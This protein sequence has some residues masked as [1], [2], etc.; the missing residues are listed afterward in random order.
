M[1]AADAGSIYA[2]TGNG[3]YDGTAN[4]GESLLRL[5]DNL[6]VA[7]SLTP[8]NRSGL[9]TGDQEMGTARPVLVPNSNLILGGNKGGTLYVLDHAQLGGIQVGNQKA[10]QTF[11]ALTG[12]IFDLALW[13]S[14]S[15][16]ILV[17]QGEQDGLKAF[18]LS[19]H[20]FA[21]EPCSSNPS[22]VASAKG[23]MAVSANGSTPGTTI[24]WITS[25]AEP[26][27]PLASGRLPAFDASDVSKELWN[28]DIKGG[29][30]TLGSFAKFANPTIAGGKVYV[31]TFSGQLVVYGLY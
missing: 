13:N 19:D 8:D 31:P 16:P 29:P 10:L 20:T 22:V 7:D 11:Q 27:D 4:F 1:A 26:S 3:D 21:T 12:P 24:R 30:D 25:S 15:G 28:S 2:I 9:N 17:V 23:G 14:A 6:C 5:T 18:C